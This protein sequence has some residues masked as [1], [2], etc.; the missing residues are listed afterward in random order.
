[1]SR[2]NTQLQQERF[3][4]TNPNPVIKRND[5]RWLFAV[6]VQ[7]ALGDRNQFRSSSR[8]D[9]LIESAVLSGFNPIHA[10]AMVAITEDAQTR[11]GLDQVAMNELLTVPAPD[12]TP[13]LSDR[14]RWIVFAALFGWACLIAGLMQLV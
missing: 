6:R 4:D 9:E 13:L 1:M 14:S 8:R 2:S 3:S 12:L 11:N 10:A 5:P 7:S